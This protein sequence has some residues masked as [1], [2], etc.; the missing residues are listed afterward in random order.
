MS[1]EED[2]LNEFEEMEL[3]E[4]LESVKL[5]QKEAGVKRFGRVNLNDDIGT[6]LNIFF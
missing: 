4:Q 6:P 1:S 5:M 3:H 2:F